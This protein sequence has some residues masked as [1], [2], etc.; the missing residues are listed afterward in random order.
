MIYAFYVSEYH[1][2]CDLT[3]GYPLPDSAGDMD[4]SH[5]WREKIIIII[6]QGPTP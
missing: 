6:K 5:H 1:L 4:F 3:N 2:T